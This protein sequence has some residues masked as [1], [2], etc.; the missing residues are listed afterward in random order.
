[1]RRYILFGGV[2]FLLTVVIWYFIAAMA[3]GFA[4]GSG[5]APTWLLI[6]RQLSRLL[7]LPLI[8]LILALDWLSRQWWTVGGFFA[9]AA[10]AVANSALVTTGFWLVRR[11]VKR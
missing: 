9:F 1:M 6:A 10:V 5:V 7:T 8:D 11:F 3:Q 2:H 4:D